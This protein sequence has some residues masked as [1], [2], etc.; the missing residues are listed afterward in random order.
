M[1]DLAA[2]R[3]APHTLNR[4]ERRLIAKAEFIFTG[5]DSLYEARKHRHENIH[6]CP[7]SIDKEHFSKARGIMP[8]P[9]DQAAIPHPRFGF[10]GVIDER[11]NLQMISEKEGNRTKDGCV[12]DHSKKEGTS[13]T[14]PVQCAFWSRT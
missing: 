13:T 10:F 11:M 14:I 2:F 4:N 8:E 6:S 5:G 1:D 7:S 12:R 3:F 9:P